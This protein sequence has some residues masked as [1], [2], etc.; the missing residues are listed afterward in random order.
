MGILTGL[1]IIMVVMGHLDMNELSWFGLFPYYSFHVMIFVFVSG[2]FYREPFSRVRESGGIS[3]I[4]SI[5]IYLGHKAFR[6]LVPYYLWNLFYGILSMGLSVR[7]FSYCHPFTFKSFLIDPWLGGHQFGLNFPAWFVPALFAVEAVNMCLRYVASCA[8]KVIVYLKLTEK[9]SEASE[10]DPISGKD[11]IDGKTNCDVGKAREIA[12]IILFVLSMTLGIMTVY[13]SKGGHVWGYYKTPGRWLMM[14]PI[15]ELGVLYRSVLEKYERLLSDA[16]AIIIACAVQAI[17]YFFS[18][19]Q[20]NFS[21]VWCTSFAGASFIPFVTSI[22]GIWLWLRIS[23][24]IEKTPI[25]TA[26]DRVGASSF[27]IMM[28]H[29]AVFWVINLITMAVCKA[30]NPEVAFDVNEYLINTNYAYLVRGLYAWK[31]VYL[32]AGLGVPLI[33]HRIASSVKTRIMQMDS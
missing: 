9:G 12:D 26:L 31:S 3:G 2:Y 10:K 5:F 6:L 32:L 28:H 16:A 17:A 19:G 21:V 30:V 14:L 27:H 1:A 15:F 18:Y 23:G 22:C 20:L 33:C 29:I 25:G 8:Q 24:M 4:R 7:G 13:L 11:L